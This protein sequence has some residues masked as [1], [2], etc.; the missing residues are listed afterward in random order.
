M[1]IELVP[2]AG[3]A[4]HF[5]PSVRALA[6]GEARAVSRL[7]YDYH[8]AAA[9]L[10][11]AKSRQGRGVE[12]EVLDRFPAGP[13]RERLA[14]GAVAVV[15]G[16]Q[17][18]F[19][20]GPLYNL[21]KAIS[22]VRVARWLEGQGVPA[23]PVFWNHSD[24]D[25]ADGLESVKLPASDDGAR[26]AA[27]KLD[28]GPLL[29]DRS[30]T[31]GLEELITLLPEG[32]GRAGAE[33]ALRGACR[34]RIAG[35]FG[36]VLS[37]WLGPELLVIEP[38]M[39]AGARSD[40][41]FRKALSH[42]DLAER[43]VREGAAALEKAGLPAPLTAPL[44]TNVYRVDGSRRE[45]IDGPRAGRLTAGVALRLIL[46]DSVLPVA[47]YI[48]GPNECAYILQLSELYR[49]FELPGPALVPRITATLVEPRVARA[50]EKL[51]LAGGDLLRPEAELQALAAERRSPGLMTELDRIEADVRSR[52]DGLEPGL[53]GIDKALPDLS[54][55]TAEKM[56][57]HLAAFRE[58]IVEA[59]RRAEGVEGGQIRRVAWNVT[60]FGG[61]QERTFTPWY[62]LAKHGS[63]LA[64]ALLG[65]LNPFADGH[66]I[67]WTSD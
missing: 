34:G 44:G 4:L 63:A 35:D 37:A 67:V 20:G 45:R 58:R 21:Y 38:A 19:A 10:R 17:P 24:D 31:G 64:S 25:K 32:P 14:A 6:G 1:R 50:A 2:L 46:Q 48:G 7:A 23:V 16:Q 41:V 55:K 13:G 40:A 26:V 60:P 27:A 22:A 12:P 3:L 61:L 54:R 28:G 11:H 49:E 42:P 5:G 57:G 36:R 52:L 15:T 51:G 18:S 43:R 29:A 33:A 39:L 47:A 8:D 30:W 9:M 66:Q 56:A 53:S 62:Y 65:G 59:R